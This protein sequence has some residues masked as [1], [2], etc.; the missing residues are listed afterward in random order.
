MLRINPLTSLNR[1]KIFKTTAFILLWGVCLPTLPAAALPSVDKLPPEFKNPLPLEGLPILPSQFQVPDLLPSPTTPSTPDQVPSNGATV[2]I[3]SV[4]VLGS[5]VFSEA[6][7][8]EAIAPWLG[9]TAT[10]ADLL[11]LRTAITALYTGKGYVTSGAF[12]P[13]QDLQGGRIKIQVVEGAIE[14]IDIEGLNRLRPGYVRDRLTRAAQTPI[15]LPDLEA[16]LQQLQRDPRFSQIQTE[17]SAGSAPGLS[18]LT[19]RLTEADPLTVQLQGHN[20]DAPSIGATRGAITAT[21][22]NLLGWGDTLSG[23][24]GTTAGLDTWAVDYTLP[25]NARNGTVRFHYDQSQSQVIEDPF[26][27]LGIVAR[28][29]TGLLE[30]RQPLVQNLTTEFTVGASLAL[31]ESRT[32]LLEDVPFSFSLGPERGVSRVTTLGLFQEW[33]QR[34]PRRVIAA[35]SQFNVGLDWFDATRNDFGIDG[36]STRWTGQLQWVEAFDRDFLAIARLG[37]QLTGDRL[38]PMEQFAVG[39]VDTVR[40]YRTNS[41]VGDNGWY[42][43]LEAR[44]TVLRDDRWGTLQITPFFDLGSSWHTGEAGSEFLSSTGLGLA[45]QPGGNI[46]MFRL[47]WGLPLTGESDRHQRGLMFSVM[48]EPQF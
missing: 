28:S 20:Y 18:R 31:R 44:F 29:K 38:L 22:L 37:G 43:S 48:V 35:R 16:A 24:Y 15:H 23:S 42:G 36:R 32:F 19:L 14:A 11:A 4:E 39:G 34:S 3:Q 2:A 7:L 45:W 40:G 10:F 5:T 9:K 12:L 30:L 21:H 13:A 25:I 6:E 17:L 26:S 1:M 33:V 8:Q 47:D 46:M 41:Q 27:S